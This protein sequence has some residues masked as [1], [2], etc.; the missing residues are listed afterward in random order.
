MKPRTE[1]LRWG[2]FTAAFDEGAHLDGW[3]GTERVAR[4]FACRKLGGCPILNHPSGRQRRLFLAL[5]DVGGTWQVVG[6]FRSLRTARRGC[7]KAVSETKKVL[8]R[9]NSPS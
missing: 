7:E 9:E 3:R 1:N 8:R 5:A 6:C 2:G 4:V